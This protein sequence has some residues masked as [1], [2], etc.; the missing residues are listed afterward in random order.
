MLTKIPFLT[1]FSTLLFGSAKKKKQDI[2]QAERREL[3][4]QCPGGLSSQLAEEIPPEFVS[5]LASNK[6]TRVYP[7][8]VTFWAFLSQVLSEDGSCAFAVAQVQEW[9]RGRKQRVPS[10][11]TG[12][13]VTARQALPESMI[14][15]IHVEVFTKLEQNVRAGVNPVRVPG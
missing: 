11:D 14:K 3:R 4:E 10:S 8:E 13:Y 7:Q 5:Q 12:S 1:G 15:S 6:R 9:M 2:L